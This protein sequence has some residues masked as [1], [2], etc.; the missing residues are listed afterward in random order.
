MGEPQ[1]Q[2]SAHLA[3]YRRFMTAALAGDT[4]AMLG[5]TNELIFTMLI[6]G[7]GRLMVGEVM[8]YFQRLSGVSPDLGEQVTVQTVAE[9]GLNLAVQYH[10]AF[11]LAP[12][13][14]RIELTAVDVVTFD[15]QGKIVKIDVFYDRADTQ[16]QAFGEILNRYL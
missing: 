3:T 10:M 12:E 8:V 1:G 4:A 13:G 11:T 6:P 14:K 2:E 5:C 7:Q 16:M 15:T 9:D